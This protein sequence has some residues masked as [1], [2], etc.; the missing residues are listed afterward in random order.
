[1]LGEIVFQ[2]ERPNYAII[3]KFESLYMASEGQCVY[4]IQN[5][6]TRYYAAYRVSY[7]H[8]GFFKDQ[9]TAAET[10]AKDI[11]PMTY[12]EAKM[13]FCYIDE[14]SYLLLEKNSVP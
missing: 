8:P 14:I 9:K 4:L 2:I 11:P 3:D 12:E 10:F 5:L 6:N 1:M 13:Y 7:T